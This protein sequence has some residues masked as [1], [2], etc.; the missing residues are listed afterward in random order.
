[1][2]QGA[3]R[4]GERGH[5]DAARSSGRRCE[6]QRSPRGNQES[7]PS[8]EFSG[9]TVDVSSQP[10]RLASRN[11]EVHGWTLV[12]PL[13]D[14]QDVKTRLHVNGERVSDAHYARPVSIDRQ[15]ECSETRITKPGAILKHG[16]RALLLETFHGTNHLACPGINRSRQ[17]AGQS[18][19]RSISRCV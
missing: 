17:G 15:N 13:A 2:P 11:I 1:V 3:P 16:D 19:R 10:K 9:G 18:R 12:P 8:S 5:P 6:D 14:S 4:S 7:Q